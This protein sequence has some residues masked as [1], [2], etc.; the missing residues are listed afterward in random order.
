[1]WI[2]LEISIISFIPIIQNSS[3]FISAESIMK[4]FIVQRIASTAMLVRVISILIGVSINNE[5][6]FMVAIIIKL[7]LAPF[8][9]WLLNV[10][11]YINFYSIFVI[12]TFLKV[13]PLCLIFQIRPNYIQIPLILRI[14]IRSI[15]CLNQ[16]SVRKVI[17]FSSIYRISLILTSVNKLF[18][19][20]NYLVLYRIILCIILII[21]RE[22]KINYINQMLF[23]EKSLLIK[24]NLWLNV[25]SIRGFPI[26]IGFSIKM[27]IIQNLIIRNFILL[28]LIILLTSIIVI[29]FYMRLAFFSLFSFIIFK[30]WRINFNKS[31]LYIL[32]INV[33]AIP[34]TA[35]F[36]RI[37]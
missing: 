7:G 13:P 30:K 26:T 34:L 15:G 24:F 21:V 22:I 37:S 6:I 2:G 8:H 25:L 12:F 20:L 32:I 16:S 35:T 11:R 4:Y 1:M 14:L 27:I 17:A 18:I 29:L 31:Q 28:S 23:N 5:L 33:I 3:N 36:M 10:V 19:W 9:N